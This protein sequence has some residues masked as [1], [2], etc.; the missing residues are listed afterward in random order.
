MYRAFVLE[1]PFDR[2]TS[3]KTKTTRPNPQ[4]KYEYAREFSE[5]DPEYEAKIRFYRQYWKQKAERPASVYQRSRPYDFDSWFNAHYGNTYESRWHDNKTSTRDEQGIGEPIE[6]WKFG[7]KS[8]AGATRKASKSSPF[9][10]DH[11]YINPIEYT[12][13]RRKFEKID[14][15]ASI[16]GIT[17]ILCG[18]MASIGFIIEST[19]LEQQKLPEKN[20]EEERIKKDWRS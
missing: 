13:R 20:K 18:L 11:I 9:D 12:I 15:I 16:V 4:R 17:L 10:F 3:A 2:R 19:D 1:S 6:A 5:R 14:D 8:S 7:Q